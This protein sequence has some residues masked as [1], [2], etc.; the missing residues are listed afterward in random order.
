MINLNAGIRILPT[1]QLT[2]VRG[3]VL[4]S[5]EV[6][7]PGFHRSFN[8]QVPFE[9]WAAVETEPGSALPEG[10][11]RLVIPEG[12]YAVFTY[13]GRAGEAAAFYQRIF[14]EWLPAS[15]YALDERP[16]I[17][18]MGEMYRGEDPSSQEEIRIPVHRR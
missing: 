14:T 10:L 4:Y 18:V 5:V 1:T 2:G 3:T 6:Y 9:K 15:G 7:P 12:V 16:H 17:A 8:P 13:R 11:D